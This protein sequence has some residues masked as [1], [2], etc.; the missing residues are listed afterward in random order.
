MKNVETSFKKYARFLES[1]QDP[2]EAMAFKQE[3]YENF[4]SVVAEFGK[5]G[6]PIAWDLTNKLLWDSYLSGDRTFVIIPYRSGAS[7]L[8]G[9]LI[10]GTDH[11]LLA[12]DNLDNKIPDDIIDEILP[13]YVG[14][15]NVRFNWKKYLA[16]SII[17][18]MRSGSSD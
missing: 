10:N 11:R 7:E 16:K 1:A 13:D 3:D 2:L 9:I 18:R 5:N 12:Y 4:K 6:I 15:G 17:G 8:A 14:V